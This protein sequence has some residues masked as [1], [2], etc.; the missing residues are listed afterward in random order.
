MANTPFFL[1]IQAVVTTD[2][3]NGNFHAGS[4]GDSAEGGKLCRASRR[5]PDALKPSTREVPHLYAGSV[6][7]KYSTPTTTQQRA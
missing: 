2:D 3:E 1:I 5:P 6:G 4:C 7:E